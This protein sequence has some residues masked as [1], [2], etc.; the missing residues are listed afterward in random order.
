MSFNLIETIQANLG[1]P[2]L[3]KIDPNTQEVKK[4]DDVSPEDFIGQAA[5]PTVLLGLYKFSRT[6]EG[7]SAI[8]NGSSN[9]HILDTIFGDLKEPVINKVSHYTNN[10]TEYTG[11]QMEK[12]AKEAI[13]VVQ[14]NLKGDTSDGA[15]TAFLSTQKTNI[16]TCLPGE[17]QIGEVLNDGSI[18]DRTHKMEG[19]MSSA[20]HWIEH[21]FTG[22]DRKKEENF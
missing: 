8:I 18:D 2:V 17:L 14:E 4:P 1:F 11:Q 6:P 7:N 9:M 19:P 5:I 12:I 20:M 22:S 15:V 21:L 13:R 10:T 3:Q 16:V